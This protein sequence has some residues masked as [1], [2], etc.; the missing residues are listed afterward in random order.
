[1]AGISLKERFINQ[2]I[3]FKLI[4]GLSLFVLPLLLLLIVHSSYA[5][6]VVSDQV[7]KSN[8]NLTTLY[9]DQID[10]NLEEVN[11]YLNVTAAFEADLL[12]LGF[13]EEKDRD[14]YQFAKINLFNKLE[15]DY[16]QYNFVDVLFVYSAENNDIL[17]NAPP[18]LASEQL[19]AMKDWL[20]GLLHGEAEELVSSYQRWFVH[21]ADDHYYLLNIKTIGNVYVGAV[22]EA[23]RLMGPLSLLELGQDGQAL[24]INAAEEVMTS[25]RSDTA[26]DKAELTALQEGSRY[27]QVR[28]PSRQG[29]FSLLIL[30]PYRTILERLPALRMMS[31]LIVLGSIIIFPLIYMFLRQII[32]VPI[33]RLIAVMRRVKDGNLAYRAEDH[34]AS[35]EFRMMNDVFNRM[36]DQ[37]EELKIHVYEEQ[38]LAQRAE[39]K[40]LQLQINPHFFLNA[41]NSIYNMAQM[42]NYALIQEMSSYMIQYMRFMFQS[43]LKFVSLKEELA[44]TR[45]YLRIQALR[46]HDGLTYR[47]DDPDF[48][49]ETEVPPLVIQTFVENT[50]KHALTMD[51]PIALTVHIACTGQEEKG[52]HIVI[53]DTGAGFPPDVLQRLQADEPV[54]SGEREHIGIW[55]IKRRLRLLYGGKARLELLNAPDGGARA[56]LY[57][58]VVPRV[59]QEL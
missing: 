33:N 9:M 46:F 4:V 21:Q 38:L 59:G 20:R 26:S 57:L 37:I 43:N 6:Q 50:V 16:P 18:S 52:L 58:P 55:N 24:L 5:I 56:E 45:N 3:R 39:L 7:T 2:S 32:L 15:N 30:L 8:E 51:D 13:P 36:V 17:T 44:H 41:L 12:P 42:R 40:H 11:T 27:L 10:R 19:K 25:Y 14:Y 31:G 53:Q 28:K 22:I 29:D 1:M 23:G 49:E 48:G 34:S 35:Y 47:L 54:I